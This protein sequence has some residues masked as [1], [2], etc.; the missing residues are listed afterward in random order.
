MNENDRAERELSERRPWETPMLR[1][2][3]LAEGT[4]AHKT[5]TFLLET[6]TNLGALVG[7]A[8]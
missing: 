2:I 4:E 6:R 1:N 7:P 3:P 8:S 5:H